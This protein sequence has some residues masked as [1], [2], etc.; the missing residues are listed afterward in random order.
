MQTGTF[1]PPFA[2]FKFRPNKSG[3]GP[4]GFEILT[5]KVDRNIPVVV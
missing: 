5:K 2:F 1:R 4:V 3:C